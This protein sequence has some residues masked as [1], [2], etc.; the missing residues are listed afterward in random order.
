MEENL[1]KNVP[2]QEEGIDFMALA[3]K[4]WEGRKTVLKCLAVFVVLGL[5]SGFDLGTSNMSGS[6]LSP[7]VYPQ[8]VSSIPFQLEL[9]HTPL[10][11]AKAD[12]AVS[13]ITYYKDY[14]KP[15]VFSYIK[16]YTIGLPGTIMGLFSK[17]KPQTTLPGAGVA[18]DNDKPKPIVLTKAEEKMLPVI[19][20]S[21]SLT[22]DKKEGYLVLSVKGTEPI[23]TA[24]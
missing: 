15:N 21:V 20:S 3:K 10:H 9:L 24:E 19:A 16:K 23:Q 2:E 8:I 13:M 22:V 12:T 18:A 6:E 5:V 7:L 17:E 1:N 4:V 11:Y 14:N